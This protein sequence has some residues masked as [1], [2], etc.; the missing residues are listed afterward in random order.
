MEFSAFIEDNVQAI[1]D[2]W[3]GFAHTLLPAAGSMSTQELRDHS[4]AMLLAIAKDMETSQTEEERLAK[5][6]DVSSP[7]EMTAAALHGAVRPR[8][9]FELV[10]VVGEFRALRARPSCRRTWPSRR[11]SSV[12]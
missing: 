5:S 3:E 7:E 12:H 8:A 4:R 6:K 10:Q 2:E 11:S 1:L 9:E